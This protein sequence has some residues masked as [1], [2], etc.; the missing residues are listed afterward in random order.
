MNVLMELKG[1]RTSAILQKCVQNKI[2]TSND[3]WLQLE[4][5]F[6]ANTLL[7]SKHYKIQSQRQ[8]SSLKKSHQSVQEGNKEHAGGFL[9]ICGVVHH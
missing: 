3:N 5:F 6:W 1:T 7:N 8:N 9:D 2:A 4:H